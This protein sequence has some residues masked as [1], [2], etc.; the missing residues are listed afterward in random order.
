LLLRQM[1]VLKR[2]I[3]TFVGAKI[4]PFGFSYLLGAFARFAKSDY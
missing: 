1:S 2:R 3:T 4:R